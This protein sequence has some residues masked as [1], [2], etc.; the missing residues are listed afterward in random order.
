MDKNYL[1]SENQRA[2]IEYLVDLLNKNNISYQITGG[3]AA[4]CYGAKRPLYDIDI[5]V[6]R[7]SILLLQELLSQYII[8]DYHH[9]QDDFFDMYLMKININGVSIDIS[10]I[11]NAYSLKNGKKLKINSSLSNSHVVSMLNMNIK[12][13]D[14]N[15]LIEYKLMVGRETDLFDVKEIK[16]IRAS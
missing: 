6:E 1:I 3:L 7:K 12:V 15:E 16:S 14:V 10:Q 2:T 9:Y 13:Q 5:D 4:L 8:D 11:E